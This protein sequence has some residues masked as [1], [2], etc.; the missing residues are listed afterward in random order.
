MSEVYKGMIENKEI[1]DKI[2]KV[3][4]DNVNSD[5]SGLITREQLGFMMNQLANDLGHPNF[6]ENEVI[7]VFDYL[8]IEKKG[9]LNFENFKVLMK[10]VLKAMD[11]KSS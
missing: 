6:L 7:E 3:A 1:L 10:D 8:D 9:S 4:F 11:N 5:K 2:T